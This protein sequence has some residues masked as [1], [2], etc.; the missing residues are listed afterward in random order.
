[1]HANIVKLFWKQAEKYQQKTLYVYRKNEKLIE[2]SWQQVAEAI[3]Y[4]AYALQS[5]KVTSGTPVG[6]L[7]NTSHFWAISDYAILSSGAITV[8]VYHSC[9]AHDI[10]Y[11]LD[12]VKVETVFVEDEDQLL[13]VISAKCDF[14][15]NI[16][17]FY[18]TDLTSDKHN[19][20]FI[21]DFIEIGKSFSVAASKSLIDIQDE[22][23]L[24]DTATII[25]TSGTSS[26]SK[27]VV[28][29]HE[30]IM[31]AIENFKSLLP[32]TDKDRFLAFLPLAH[33]FER[34]SSHFYGMSCGISVCFCSNVNDLKELLSI[35]ECTFMTVV[36]RLLEKLYDRV[37]ANLATL[38]P[39]IKSLVM[40]LFTKSVRNKISPKLKAFISGGAPLS[41]KTAEFY[42]KI[43]IKVLEGYGLTESSGGICI[44]P[45]KDIRIGT[46]GQPFD[47]VKVKLAEDNEILLKGKSIFKEYLDNAEATASAFGEGSANE[48]WFHTGDLGSLDKDG[49]LSIIG[50]KKE[51]IVTSYGKKVVMAKLEN[52]LQTSPYISQAVV[53][54]D[55]QKYIV[56][57]LVV[58]ILETNKYFNNLSIVDVIEKQQALHELLDEE[59]SK[60]NEQLASYEQIKKYAILTRDLSIEEGELT[61]TLK[62]KRRVVEEKYRD[63]ISQMYVDDNVSST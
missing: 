22:I 59:I 63:Q 36:P 56:A 40:N 47:S 2:L 15:K 10:K 49:Y 46:V 24:S 62:V 51:L 53:V 37:Q 32:L 4:L 1:M 6:I 28:L 31:G 30:N 13:K 8:P 3:S 5:L 39:V 43:G 55:K 61:P 57:L 45:P 12:L 9:L 20:Y 17:T 21:D 42:N 11:Q 26:K 18:K 54:G 58:N 27:A 60:L 41:V 16:I 44:N 50:R 25:F 35:S 34:T 38:Q 19:I 52:L 48:G 29:T 14:V 7:A 23:K 33:I